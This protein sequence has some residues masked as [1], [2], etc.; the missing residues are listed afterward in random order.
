MNLKALDSRFFST[1]CS[2]L[3]SVIMLRARFWSSSTSNDSW[4]FSASCRNGRATVSSRLDGQDFLGVDRHRAGLDLR[5]IED[6]ADQIEQVGAGAVDGA[7][8]LDLLGRSDCR[9]G[10]R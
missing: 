1:C 6:V 2:R 5:Q 9:P 8:E 10:F 4:R 7:G 3:E